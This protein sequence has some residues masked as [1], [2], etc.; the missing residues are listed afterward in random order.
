MSKVP[1][2][3]I[4]IAAPSSSGSAFPVSTTVIVVVVVLAVLAVLAI[5]GWREPDR[6]PGADTKTQRERIED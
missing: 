3:I 6:S 2:P 4:G 1:T 5:I